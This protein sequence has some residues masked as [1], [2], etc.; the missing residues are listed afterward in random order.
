MSQ[1]KVG[2]FVESWVNILIGF[3]I[4]YVANLTVLPLFGYDVSY[5]DAFG[6]GI[7]F[8]GI[9]LLRSYFIRRWFNSL[10][11]FNHGNEEVHP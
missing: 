11:L 1:T 5:T 4:N 6:I 10:K 3:S 7:V 8:T 2:S 9:S